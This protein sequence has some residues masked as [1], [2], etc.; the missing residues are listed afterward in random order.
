MDPLLEGVRDKLRGRYAKSNEIAGRLTSEWADRIGMRE[1]IPVSVGGLDGYWDALGAGV[2]EGDVVTVL[3]SSAPIMA[4]AGN[5]SPIPG[6]CG[7]T[8]GSIHPDM[9]LSRLD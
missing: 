5:T 3:G 6:T 2:R 9:L 4:L 8:F 7:A 1:A